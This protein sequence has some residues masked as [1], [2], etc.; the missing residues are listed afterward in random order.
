MA[1]TDP[2]RD[3]GG[4]RHRLGLIVL[5]T[6]LAT[7]SDWHRSLAGHD[8][9]FHTTRIAN[10]NPVTPENLRKMGPQLGECAARILPEMPL[11][12]VAYSCTSATAVLGFDAVQDQIRQGRAG[13]PV[14]T[15]L[16]AGASGLHSFGVRRISLVTPYLN[17]LGEGVAQTFASLGFDVVNQSHMDIGS[18]ADMA[19]VPPSSIA[20]FVAQADHPDAQA[21]FISC[22]A[23]RAMECVDGL[24]RRLGK[25]VLSSIQCL[26]WDALRVS[27]YGAPVERGGSLLRLP[28]C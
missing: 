10:V 23:I 11:D 9:A 28:R 26:L 24:E 12:V 4:A 15:P 22:T 18:D 17:A 14:V 8:V 20:E 25:P 3:S 21:V 13:V 16:T 27:G 19:Y 6:D 7:E 5:A 2:T 1:L